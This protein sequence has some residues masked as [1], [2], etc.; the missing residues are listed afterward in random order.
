MKNN[1]KSLKYKVGVPTLAI[2]LMMGTGA[3][4]SA[5]IEAP[6][7][8][9]TES[10]NKA[11][12]SA[13][14]DPF[15]PVGYVPEKLLK[16]SMSEA[17]LALKSPSGTT[18]WNIAM[19]QVVISGVSS[20]AGNEFFAVINGEI[21]TVGEQVSVLNSGIQYIWQIDSITPPSSVKLRRI[22][23]Q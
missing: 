1:C 21:K 15:W 10:A 9:G 8:A 16:A 5:Q 12:T 23:A 4:V 22:A 6:P 17:Q 13:Q 7:E 19:K 18:D 3:L 20:R 11:E 14:R 2:L